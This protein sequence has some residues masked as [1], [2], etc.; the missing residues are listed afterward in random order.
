[1]RIIILGFN[2]CPHCR[3]LLRLL[4]EVQDIVS[5]SY[6]EF[7]DFISTYFSDVDK[8]LYMKKL[9][10]DVIGLPYALYKS[11]D[12]TWKKLHAE[13]FTK[14]HLVKFAKSVTN[15]LA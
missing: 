2:N 13:K 14:A 7:S 15:P 1:M 5:I 9:Q 10:K 11:K 6:I 8:E 3:S 12:G 4:K